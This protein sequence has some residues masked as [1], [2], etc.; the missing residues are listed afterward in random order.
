MRNKTG[1]GLRLRQGNKAQS[2]HCPP[3][4]VPIP[5]KVGSWAWHWCPLLCCRNPSGRTTTLAELPCKTHFSIHELHADMSASHDP[6]PALD[7]HDIAWLKKKGPSSQEASVL[8]KGERQ[9]SEQRTR[10]AV[11]DKGEW[12]PV[13]SGGASHQV[14]RQVLFDDETQSRDREEVREEVTQ[15]TETEC[16]KERE[17]W[18]SSLWASVSLEE[19][20]GRTERLGLEKAAVGPCDHSLTKA[21]TEHLMWAVRPREEQQGAIQPWRR[22]STHSW[23]RTQDPGRI[24]GGTRESSAKFVEGEHEGV[25]RD[26]CGLRAA[27]KV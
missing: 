9:T 15:I 17:R 5:L 23:L 19:P 7:T 27:E 18:A 22:K 4:L 25:R 26:S 24:T 20:H 8:V 1:P 10:P 3:W 6:D 21:H 16:S 14:V 13:G 2:T 12:R 11:S